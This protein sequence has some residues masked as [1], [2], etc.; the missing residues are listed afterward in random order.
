MH[1]TLP[2][3]VNFTPSPP[4]VAPRPKLRC[5]KCFPFIKS[6]RASGT[7]IKTCGEDGSW[8]GDDDGICISKETQDECFVSINN[9]N[10]P[11]YPTPKLICPPNTVVEL[12]EFSDEVEVKIPRPKTDLNIRRDVTVKPTWIKGERIVLRM[13]ELNITFTAK[14]PISKQTSSCTTTFYVVGGFK[15]SNGA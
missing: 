1:T 12:P 9:S 14:H 7:F 2:D 13:G 6:Y 11:E 15:W 3:Q 10:I 4:P 5:W 8:H